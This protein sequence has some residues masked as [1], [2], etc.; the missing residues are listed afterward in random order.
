MSVWGAT[1]LGRRR[2]LGHLADAEQA[3][4]ADALDL[5]GRPL[6]DLVH[7]QDPSR[8]LE[9]G[10]PLRGELAQLQVVDDLAG[11]EDDGGGDVLAEGPVRDGEGHA[12]ARPPDA[13]SSTSSISRG[14]I[15]SPPR[16][17][18]SFRRPVRNR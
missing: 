8:H 10:Q 4:E 7:D 5:A 18:I 12:P 3:G 1:V 14:A 11:P 2:R 13:S 15:F 17:M 9:V 16:L 6:R